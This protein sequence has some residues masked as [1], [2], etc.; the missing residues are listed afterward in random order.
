MRLLHL[1]GGGNPS[2]TEF[3][4]DDIP[5]Y[6]IL[7]HRWEAEEVT[8]KDMTDGTNRIKAGYGKIYFCGEQARR[9]GLE[10]FWVDTC[11][12]DK[13]SSAELSEAINSM[14]RWYQKAARC[15]VYLSDVSIGDRKIISQPSNT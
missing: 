12:I 8:F 6:A 4:E 14:F 11:C 7:S 5:E 3:F 9:D 13:S 1:D 15:Y 10:Y 2:L